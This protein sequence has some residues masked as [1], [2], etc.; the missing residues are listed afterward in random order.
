VS[1]LVAPLVGLMAG[2]R[3]AHNGRRADP[4]LAPLCPYLLTI[5]VMY[6]FVLSSQFV[7]T[8]VDRTGLKPVRLSQGV[9]DVSVSSKRFLRRNVVKRGDHF[10]DHFLPDRRE[11]FAFS[12]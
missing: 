12:G 10:S 7:L 5:E 11:P 8:E 9:T 6:I 4:Q 2:I 1:G 3:Q